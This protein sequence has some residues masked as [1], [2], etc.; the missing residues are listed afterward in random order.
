MKSHFFE[1]KSAPGFR[2]SL[3][4][5]VFILLVIVASVVLYVTLHS[6]VIAVIPLHLCAVFFLFCNVFRIRTKQELVWVGSYVASAVYSMATG[7]NFWLTVLMVPTPMIVVVV[8]WAVVS[9]GYRGIFASS[10]DSSR[11]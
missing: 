11:R 6:A 4:D 10:G 3:S 2:V 1:R 7:T 5:L 9:G 8:A